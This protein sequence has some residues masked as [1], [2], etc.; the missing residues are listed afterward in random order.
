LS[1][2]SVTVQGDLHCHRR[3]VGLGRNFHRNRRPGGKISRCVSTIAGWLHE[4]QAL[5]PSVLLNVAIVAAVLV[6]LVPGAVLEGTFELL[7]DAGALLDGDGGVDLRRAVG[8]Y[9]GCARSHA[10]RNDQRTSR[11]SIAL[12]LH[13]T[14]DP[15]AAGR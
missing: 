2:I 13:G 11:T 10:A 5:P 15:P 7:S 8:A 3:C 14:T 9:C 12:G 6:E 4:T 1:R